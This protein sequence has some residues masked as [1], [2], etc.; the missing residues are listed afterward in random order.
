[1]AANEQSEN[2][3]SEAEAFEQLALEAIASI[4]SERRAEVDDICY[5]LSA[6]MAQGE[7]PTESDV[8]RLRQA[9]DGIRDVTEYY[10]T[11]ASEGGRERRESEGGVSIE[12]LEDA[13][14]DD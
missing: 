7:K 9:A 12:S 13:E 1:M 3:Q 11:E 2:E 8:R 5:E 10:I 6:K 4:L 14:S